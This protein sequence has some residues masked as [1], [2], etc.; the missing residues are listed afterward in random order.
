MTEAGGIGITPFRSMLQFLLDRKER[1]PIVILYGI[2][3]QQ[4]VAYRDVHLRFPASVWAPRW[5]PLSPR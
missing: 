4:V 5:R 3:G 2:E 1:R